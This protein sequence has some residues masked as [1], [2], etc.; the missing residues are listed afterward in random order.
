MVSIEIT[1][2]INLLKGDTLGSLH[3][4]KSSTRESNSSFSNLFPDFIEED[5]DNIFAV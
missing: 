2:K 4:N 3:A 5:F 1:L